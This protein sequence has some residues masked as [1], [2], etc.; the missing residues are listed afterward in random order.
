MAS[1]GQG[2]TGW[3]HNER[4]T[5]RHWLQWYNAAGLD[6]LRTMKPPG[7]PPELDKRQRKQLVKIVD[8]GPQKAGFISGVWTGPMIGELIHQ[9]FGVKYH[10]HH[11][12]RLL[13]QL[14]F[15]VQRP[16]KR[17]AKADREAQEYWLRKK[18]PAIKKSIESARCRPIRG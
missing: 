3:T 14:G 15:S 12:P 16:R 10:N 5:S 6:G 8:A 18:L 9:R 11:V 17:L 13:H 4:L 1:G 2:K 7:R